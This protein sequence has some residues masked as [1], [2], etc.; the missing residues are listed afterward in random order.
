M[1]LES[2]LPNVSGFGL[3]TL[4][5]RTAVRFGLIDF[6]MD[7]PR[8]EL[9]RRL[10]AVLRDLCLTPEAAA[11]VSNAEFRLYYAENA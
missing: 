8:D 7:T 1:I 11:R 6:V 4:P 5:F 9:A 3:W 10:L 2:C